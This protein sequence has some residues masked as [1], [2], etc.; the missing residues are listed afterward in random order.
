[1]SETYLVNWKAVE[2]SSYVEEINA[3]DGEH[4][5]RKIIS[6]YTNYPGYKGLKIQIIS[7]KKIG[8]RWWSE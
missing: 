1:M 5:K 7:V 4:A 2:K 6:K 8:K 3:N